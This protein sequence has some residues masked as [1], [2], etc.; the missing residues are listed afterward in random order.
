[1]THAKNRGVVQIDIIK[2]I[3]FALCMDLLRLA[4]LASPN[5]MKKNAM[6]AIKK[7]PSSSTKI[8]LLLLAFLRSLTV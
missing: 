7:V 6:L 4:R 5:G 1:M 8:V 3:P 2:V